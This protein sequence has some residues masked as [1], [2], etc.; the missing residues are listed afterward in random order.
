LFE[1]IDVHYGEPITIQDAASIVYLSKSHFMKFFKRVT[2]QAFVS[3][4]NHFRIAKAQVL[5]TTTD[6]PFS[7]VSQEVGFCD[8]SYFGLVFRKLV[9]VSPRE[10]KLHAAIPQPLTLT[11]GLISKYSPNTEDSWRVK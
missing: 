9:H 11:T 5:L 1:Y 8:Q 4:L 10:Y 3:Y 6:L 7:E 2:G